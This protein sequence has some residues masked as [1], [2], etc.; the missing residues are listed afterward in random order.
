MTSVASFPLK[1]PRKSWLGSGELSSKMA[2][3][4]RVEPCL[5]NDNR[6]IFSVMMTTPADKEQVD[7]HC[8]RR[9]CPDR[10]RLTR[11]KCRRSAGN[12]AVTCGL[13]SGDQHLGIRPFGPS[14]LHL[15]IFRLIGAQAAD[16][17]VTFGP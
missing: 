12:V 8:R 10:R 7:V 2:A 17:D 14:Q 16:A 15:F 6:G 1:K 3:A 5:I 4:V 13:I 11:V 9:S